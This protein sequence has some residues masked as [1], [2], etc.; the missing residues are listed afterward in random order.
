MAKKGLRT[1]AIASCGSALIIGAPC[2]WAQVAKA[3]QPAEQAD[4]SALTDIAV[5]SIPREAA[6]QDVPVPVTALA[7][8]ALASADVSKVRTLTQVMP[9]FVGSRNM[10]V[11]QPV[12]RGV[13]LT[14]IS[15]GDEP[16]IATYVD[17]VYQPEPAATSIDLV[18][19]ERVGG[20]RPTGFT[21]L[22]AKSLGYSK[23][24]F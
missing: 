4:L 17:S 5:T 23:Q 21:S 9:A 3:G 20:R 22:T 2:A 6:L 8:D 19:V 24:K 13:G 10:G 14:G 1:F 12:F 7:A 16:D 11:F 18:E 15:L